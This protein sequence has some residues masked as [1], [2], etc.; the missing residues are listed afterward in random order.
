MKISVAAPQPRSYEGALFTACPILNVAIINTRSPQASTSADASTQPGDY[1]AIP[2]SRIQT[3]Q[4]VSLAAGAEAGDGSF[5]N[6]Q[7]AIGPVD[8][9]RLREREQ[10]KINKLKEDER[11]RGKGV[12]KEA[13]AIFDSFKRMYVANNHANASNS[14][15]TVLQ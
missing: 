8:T 4:V 13:Q 1:H 7:P 12:T 15:L 5:A 10:A 6:A 3:F 9:R 11:N 14:P 2:F